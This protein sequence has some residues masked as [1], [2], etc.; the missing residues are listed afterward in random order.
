MKQRLVWGAEESGAEAPRA[1]IYKEASYVETVNNHIYFY[2]EVGKSE[3]LQLNKH[4]RELNNDLLYNAKVQDRDPA[5]IFLHINSYGGSIFDGL[6][7]MDTVLSCRVPVVTIIDGC[8]ASAATFISVVGKER[9][10]PKHGFM[11]IHQLTAMAWGKYRELQDDNINFNKLMETIKAIYAEYT[12]IPAEK[13]AE[14]LDHDLW[15][16]A[17]KCLEYGM[18][19]KII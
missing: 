3:I 2:S 1:E 11:L 8:C 12:K 17:K 10:I 5:S 18:V 15:F 6:A 9:F 4:I 14:I 13:I 16:D 7:A 19:D